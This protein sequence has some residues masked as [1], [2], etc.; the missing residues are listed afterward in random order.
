MLGQQIVRLL[1]AYP[2]IYLACHRRHI[3]DD[4]RGHVVTDSQA[5]VLA[6]LH[7]TRPVTLSTIARHLGIGCSAMSIAIAKLVRA[8]YVRRERAEKDGRAI[9]LTL[10]AAGVRITEQNTVLDEDLVRELFRM[11]RPSELDAALHGM[12]LL[13]QYANALVALRSKGRKR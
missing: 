4:E 2:A 5:S 10:T 13:A 11:M 7:A 1:E 3:R 12:E 6:H 8:G 9:H